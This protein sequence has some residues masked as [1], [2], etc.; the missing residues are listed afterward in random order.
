MQILRYWHGLKNVYTS[1][2][3]TEICLNITCVDTNSFCAYIYIYMYVYIQVA[4]IL[5]FYGWWTYQYSTY[6][7]MI[8]PLSHVHSITRGFCSLFAQP[9]ARGF[10]ILG[11]LTTQLNG[12][13]LRWHRGDHTI[14]LVQTKQPRGKV[15]NKLHE[16]FKHYQFNVRAN[17]HT[18][19]CIHCG[20]IVA[21]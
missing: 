3:R 8:S 12:R 20:S 18:A 17:Q 16:S 1:L 15:R 9:R 14:G 7:K 19:V 4:D 5:I 13:P 11:L 6:Y 10:W 2:S 21:T